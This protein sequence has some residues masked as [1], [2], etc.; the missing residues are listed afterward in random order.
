MRHPTT[1]GGDAVH[2]TSSIEVLASTMQG[3]PVV[4]GITG[5]VYS[6]GNHLLFEN[7]VK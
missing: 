5:G 3:H 4:Q 2:F 6:D 7:E 1:G